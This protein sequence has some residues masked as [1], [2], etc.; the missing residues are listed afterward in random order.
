MCMPALMRIP[1]DL[2]FAVSDKVQPINNH[3]L[4]I[5]CP[6]CGQ[7]SGGGKNIGKPIFTGESTALFYCHNCFLT[8]DDYE[9]IPAYTLE[10]IEDGHAVIS[11][12][13]SFAGKIEHCFYERV[14]GDCL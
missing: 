5:T 1:V 8:T 14:V 3:W 9:E 13:D 4:E 11:K 12:L 7:V 10:R 2:N 6:H